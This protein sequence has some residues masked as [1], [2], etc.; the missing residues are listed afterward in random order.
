MS[1]NIKT[2]KVITI[3]SILLPTL[4]LSSSFK[5]TKEDL[6]SLVEGEIKFPK[7]KECSIQSNNYEDLLKC[8]DIFEVEKQEKLKLLEREEQEIK[9]VKTL[10]TREKKLLKK[11]KEFL[12][13][14]A[15]RAEIARKELETLKNKRK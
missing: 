8:I 15:K 5:N 7:T 11:R 3:C 12:K 2:S 13:R 10:T 6:I 14:K 1:K 9:E 4:L